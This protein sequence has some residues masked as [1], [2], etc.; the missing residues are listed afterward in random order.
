[1]N[2]DF[3]E[4]L[5]FDERNEIQFSQLIELSGLS[6]ADLR[7]L[8]DYGALVPVDP[9]ASSWV[10]SAHSVILAQTACRLRHDFELDAPALSVVL[11]LVER[12][13]A[14]E[15]ELRAVR[16]RSSSSR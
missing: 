8:V 7:E 16:A 14:L 10:F 9:Q 1:M 4:A 3:A 11:G 12:I 6:E 5:H 13:A 15:D 2:L